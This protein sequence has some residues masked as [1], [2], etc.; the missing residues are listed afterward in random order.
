MKA[1]GGENKPRQI[2]ELIGD[3]DK[4]ASEPV[5]VTDEPWKL[6]DLCHTNIYRI[7][8]LNLKMVFE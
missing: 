4:I 2:G 6:K 3:Y 5:L 8:E 1:G 7:H